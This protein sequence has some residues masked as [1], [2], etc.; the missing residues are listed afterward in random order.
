MPIIDRNQPHREALIWYIQKR[1]ENPRYVPNTFSM[2]TD[3]EK[4]NCRAQALSLLLL[5]LLLLLLDND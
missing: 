5:L 1:N 2:L 3:G 4:R